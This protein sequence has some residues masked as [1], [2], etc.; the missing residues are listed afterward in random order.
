MPEKTEVH[1]REGEKY[2]FA[3][4]LPPKRADFSEVQL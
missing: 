3:T 1:H 4:P 2:E